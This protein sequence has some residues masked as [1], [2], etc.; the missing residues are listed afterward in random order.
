MST[1]TGRTAPEASI[2]M[3]LI[4]SANPDHRQFPL[5]GDVFD[6]NREARQHLAFVLASA[7]H[8]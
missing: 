5:D 2:M 4:A 8:K 7:K 1:T 6:I 3:V